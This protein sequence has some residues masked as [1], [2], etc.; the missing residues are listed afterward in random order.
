MDQTKPR[1]FIIMPVSFPGIRKDLL[2]DTI[3]EAFES[4][5]IPFSSISN[6]KIKDQKKDSL[7]KNKDINIEG[8]KFQKQLDFAVKT[9][10]QKS[11]VALIESS[12]AT[13]SH[14]HIIYL[15]KNHLPNAFETNTRFLRNHDNSVN[16]T[17]VALIPSPDGDLIG[18]EYKGKTHQYPLTGQLFHNCLVGILERREEDAQAGKSPNTTDMDILFDCLNTFKNVEL[19]QTS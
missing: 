9:D 19:T 8:K 13:S 11:L 14:P 18:F 5:N 15:E 1:V 17:L 3:K 7:A 6:N 4:K 16:M 10:F 12:T 2:Y